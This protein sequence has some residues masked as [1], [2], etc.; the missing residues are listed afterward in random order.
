MKFICLLLTFSKVSCET[1]VDVFISL[2]E[3][4]YTIVRNCWKKCYIFYFLSREMSFAHLFLKK[5]QMYHQ[6]HLSRT[7]KSPF[8]SIVSGVCK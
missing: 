1:S 4:D 3:S 2:M 6:L 8:Y 7:E 5:S